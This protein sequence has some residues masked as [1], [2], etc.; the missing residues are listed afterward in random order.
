VGWG[1]VGWGG[2]GWGGVGWDG[3]GWGGVGWGGVGW[4]GV[5]WGGVGWGGVGWGGVGWG[6]VGWGGVGWG[7]VG[8]VGC[9]V[10]GGV[11]LGGVVMRGG[12]GFTELAICK[13]ASL[14][15]FQTNHCVPVVKPPWDASAIK[16]PRYSAALRLAT[17]SLIM[18]EHMYPSASPVSA[19]PCA[20]PGNSRLWIYFILFIF[21]FYIRM[22]S[23]DLRVTVN[24]E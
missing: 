11:G 24:F 23:A 2:V 5:G 18:R 4:G 20:T 17:G 10:W 19:A 16:L 13:V 3:V 7:G 21:L 9:G 1:G 14:S 12:G 15:N 6:G 8:W 22:L